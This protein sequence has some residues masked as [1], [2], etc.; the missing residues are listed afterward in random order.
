[1]LILGPILALNLARTKDDGTLEE[2]EKRGR[3][4]IGLLLELLAED[5]A[6]VANLMIVFRTD[7]LRDFGPALAILFY[8]KQE[9]LLL[10]NGPL[11]RDPLVSLHGHL[12]LVP[13]P[14]LEQVHRRFSHHCFILDA[15][16]VYLVWV[17]VGAFKNFDHTSF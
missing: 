14:L 12:C 15:G 9:I 10:L 8:S 6:K 11:L 2:L 5:V 13:T 16:H 17:S 3:L 7:E 1:M 4:T